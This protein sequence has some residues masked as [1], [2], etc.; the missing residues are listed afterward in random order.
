LSEVDETINFILD[1]T[2]VKSVGETEE[3]HGKNLAFIYNFIIDKFHFLTL[4]EI[5]EAF[6][7]FVAKQFEVKVFRMIDCVVVGEV[8]YS[9]IEYR[10]NQ[11][12]NYIP[13]S[14]EKP[15]LEVIT[16]SAKEDINKKAVNRV[17]NEFKES[18]SLPDGLTYIYEILVENALIKVPN[19]NTPK[20]NAYYNR[21]IYEAQ[22][23]LIAEKKNEIYKAKLGLDKGNLFNLNE[24][25]KA[26][27]E[28]TDNSIILRA[29]KLVLKEFFVSKILANQENIFYET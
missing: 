28:K 20:L 3:E 2:G 8:L 11:L 9:Y 7:M 18:Q 19:E 14:I 10:N 27:E 25:L 12:I 17:Y 6:R 26:I 1:I 15:K 13:E 4:E 24:N 5:K 23:E 21:K 22:K 16:N 29:K